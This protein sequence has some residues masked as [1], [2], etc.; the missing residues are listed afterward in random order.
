MSSE[1]SGFGSFLFGGLIGAAL[2]V[3]FAPRPGVETR[4]IVREKVQAYLDNAD[5]INDSVRDR[6]VELYSVASGRAGEASEQLK[7]KIDSARARLSETVNAAA[8]TAATTL[9]AAKAAIVDGKEAD[10]DAAP[11]E[12]DGAADANAEG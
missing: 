6:A 4:A 1:K 12:A 11:A 3:L 5:V 2:G 8:D 10:E 9:A 7:E